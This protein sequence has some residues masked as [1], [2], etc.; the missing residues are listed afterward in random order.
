MRIRHAVGS[1]KN[2]KVEALATTMMHG[3]PPVN[4]DRK[5]AQWKVHE[6]YKFNYIV[7]TGY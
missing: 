4:P 3:I 5:S 7:G 1:F 2:D 6:P